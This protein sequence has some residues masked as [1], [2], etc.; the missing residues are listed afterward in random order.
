MITVVDVI[1]SL[2]IEPEPRLTW[3]VGNAVRALYESR[4]GSLP[5]KDLRGKTSG[6]GSHCFAIY[7]KHMKTDIEKIVR[8][9]QVQAARQLNL[10]I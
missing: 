5:E 1:R 9:H 3:S 6:K 4:N 7:P 8:S 2:G 10:D